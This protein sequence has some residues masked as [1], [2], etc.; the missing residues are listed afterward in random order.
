MNVGS[1][2]VESDRRAEVDEELDCWVDN[3]RGVGSSG[4][5][6]VSG[7]GDGELEC[8]LRCRRARETSRPGAESE[9]RGVEAVARSCACSSKGV[10]GGVRGEERFEP[11]E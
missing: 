1:M 11:I 6:V 3:G 5:G 2:V 8:R 7:L 10:E 9:R 4:S